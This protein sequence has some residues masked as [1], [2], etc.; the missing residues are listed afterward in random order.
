M[1]P[2]GAAAMPRRKATDLS[3]VEGLSANGGPPL[4]PH[5]EEFCRLYAGDPFAETYGRLERSA[6]E[7]GVHRRTLSRWLDEPTVRAR[8]QEYYDERTEDLRRMRPMIEAAGVQAAAKLS[9]IVAQLENLELDSPRSYLARQNGILEKSVILP[10]EGTV[11]WSRIEAAVAQH[12]RNLLLLL[13]EAL[14]RAETLLNHTI[15]HPPTRHELTV[16]DEREEDEFSKRLRSM[17]IEQKQALLTFLDGAI[18]MIEEEKERRALVPGG[19]MDC[20]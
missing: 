15:G 17:S 19:E 6:Q 3:K 10:A 2:L 4:D 12:N 16:K 18:A 9:R 20:A 11:E 13:K 14:G 7:L 5:Q 1:S 8:I